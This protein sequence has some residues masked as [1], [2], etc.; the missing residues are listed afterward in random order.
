VLNRRP[1][2]GLVWELVVR[3]LR[4]RYRRSAL[5]V[6]WAQVAPL[7]YVLVL[8]V[9]FT[10]VV[11]LSIEHYPVFVLVGMLPWLW[12][13]AALQAGTTS[14]VDAPDLLRQPGFPRM[15]L[16]LVSV[17]STLAQHVLALPVAIGA[18]AIVTGRVPA[19]VVAL[20]PLL[21]LQALLCAGPAFALASAHSRLRDTARLVTVALVPL[22][23]ATPVF[24]DESA[25]DAA[26]LL[27]LNPMAPIVDGY[28]AA[29]LRGTWP[30]PVPLG[31]V[32]LAGA[33]LLAA[34]ITLYRGRMGRFLEEL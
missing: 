12:F 4:L 27:R 29:L 13:Q 3:D 15:A 24:Y 8:T 34:G 18:A 20:V 22:F 5:G 14:V 23:Y 9:V 19:T 28:R 26:P 33:V 25:L 32:A 6:L 31:V 17:G 11:P 16:P 2:S 30:A 1:T 21:A 10:R 7:S